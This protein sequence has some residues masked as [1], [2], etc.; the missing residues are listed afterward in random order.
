MAFA[1]IVFVLW[2]GA[3]QVTAG[4]MTIGELTQFVLYAVF[5]A[6]SSSPRL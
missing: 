5:I 6:G 1:V 3:R 4:A 2:M